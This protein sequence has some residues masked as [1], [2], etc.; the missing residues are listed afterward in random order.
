MMRGT[1]LLDRLRLRRGRSEP[2]GEEPK[3]P[4][5][6]PEV[7][8]RRRVIGSFDE[9]L[10]EEEVDLKKL[11]NCAWNGIPRSKRRGVWMLL[12]GYLPASQKTR[13][14]ALEK[15]RE[16]FEECLRIHFDETPP[17]KRSQYLKETFVQITK[18]IPR[19]C[20]GIPLFTQENIR[21]LMTRVLFA[22][23][24]KHPRSGY[25]QGMNDLLAII[26]LVF[27]AD[28]AG[29]FTS[30]TS[31]AKEADTPGGYQGMTGYSGSPDYA[32]PSQKRPA[33]NTSGS[34]YYSESPPPKRVPSSGQM[35]RDFRSVERSRSA[36][37]LETADDLED[38][39]RDALLLRGDASYLSEDIMKQI[40]ADSYFCL[41][42]ILEEIQDHYVELQ[43]GLQKAS[44]TVH[45]L[46]R[47]VDLELCRHLEEQGVLT[48]QVT[49]RWINCLLVRE[50]PVP[51]LVRLWD[52]CIAED[53]GFLKFF[54]YICAA[55][56]CHFSDTLRHLNAENLHLF[57]QNLPTH[58]W[59]FKDVDTLL[60]EAYILNTLFQDSPCH[61]TPDGLGLGPNAEPNTPGGANTGGSYAANYTGL[62]PKGDVSPARPGS[63]RSSFKIRISSD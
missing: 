13:G 22:W 1:N 3:E 19:T 52:A 41:E 34:F 44:E 58:D 45:N 56:L 12:L 39:T 36:P 40:A 30:K 43:P 51:A 25:V 57:L 33:Y 49:F 59:T 35:L 54:P 63:S 18:D 17:E 60:G 11:R 5:E 50:L 27:I 16:E 32:A 24:V 15:K 26:L 29:V 38:P 55:F 7:G 4:Q 23:G 20:P 6:D 47:R 9:I 2:V 37:P 28:A 14:P 62:P 46:L 21:T 53:R 31:K 8:F 10:N 61:L 42:K 48:L